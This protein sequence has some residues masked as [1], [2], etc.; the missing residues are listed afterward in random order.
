MTEETLKGLVSIAKNLNHLDI[1]WA[2][3][4]SLLLYLEGFD[5]SVADIDLVVHEEDHTLLLDMLKDYTYTHQEPNYI[6]K[7]EHFYSLFSEG[8]DVDIMVNFKVLKED[9]VYV[10]PFHIE[11]ELEIDNTT[12]FC[13]SVD[14]WLNAYKAMNRIDKVLLIQAN[15]KRN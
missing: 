2:L 8:I 13:S 5:I 4:A 10:F 9:T 6:Y 7:T 14:E 15:K 1:R 11:K 3:G 12:I